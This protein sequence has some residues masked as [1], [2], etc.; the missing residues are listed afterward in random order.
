MDKKH[1]SICIFCDDSLRRSSLRNS[2]KLHNLEAGRHD[3]SGISN[4][5]YEEERGQNGIGELFS[6]FISLWYIFC[7]VTNEKKP[8]KHF[9]T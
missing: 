2:K 8:S 5:S 6:S 4:G 9:N 3:A 1:R 7:V